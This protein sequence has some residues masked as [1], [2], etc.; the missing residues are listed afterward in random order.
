M[1][2]K[3]PS[4]KDRMIEKLHTG[5]ARFRGGSNEDLT[6][7]A[8][9][10][11]KRSSGT[12]TWYTHPQPE[13]TS[14]EG[15]IEVTEV[16]GAV[17]NGNKPKKVPPEGTVEYKVCGSDTLASIAA[18]FDTTPTELQ[19]LNR[20]STRNVFAGQ[21][22]YV[23]ASL[24]KLKTEESLENS[25]SHVCS[26]M[27]DV[28]R[29][30][31]PLIKMAD[32]PPSRVPGHVERIP[33]PISSPT[34]EKTEFHVPHK[35][36]EEEAR[37][38]DQECYERFIKVHAKHITDGQA[39]LTAN[40]D[41]KKGVVS[42]VLLVTPNAVMFDPNVSD[43]LVLEHGAERYGVIA[44]MDMVVSAAM[45][46]DIAA[47]KVKGQRD[48]SKK[49]EVYHDRSC[50][51]FKSWC[52]GH[53][54]F[55][56]A[57]AASYAG[58]NEAELV[59]TDITCTT[60]VITPSPQSDTA[61]S[62]SCST[63]Q[64][65]VSATNSPV[66]GD[67]G[68]FKVPSIG[69]VTDREQNSHIGELEMTSANEFGEF[70]SSESDLPDFEKVHDSFTANETSTKV[71]SNSYEIPCNS[72]NENDLIALDTEPESRP[73]FF[74]GNE[75]DKIQD[76]SPNLGSSPKEMRIGNIVYLPV[77]E[78]SKGPVSAEDIESAKVVLSKLSVEEFE[79]Q[80]SQSQSTPVDI[81][82]VQQ[83][84]RSESR[85][86]SFG[87][88]NVA[89]HLNA[90]VNYATGLFK[91]G[92][93]I[94][95]VGEVIPDTELCKESKGKT[96][97]LDIKGKS[98]MIKQ[99]LR[100]LGSSPKEKSDPSGVDLEVAVENAV[101]LADKPEL[102]QS[103]DKLIPR[104]AVAAEDPP[105]YLC[106]HLGKPVNKLVS[107]TAPIQAYNK[108]KKKP[109]Y[110]FSIPREKVDQ[111]YAF[112]VQW[113][114]ELYGDEEEI[115]AERRGFV[116]LD[117]EEREDPEEMEVF[118]EYFN[119]GITALQKDWEIISAEEA[120]RR[121]SVEFEETQMLPELHGQST[122][123][124][125]YHLEMLN[126][127]MPPRT[128]GYPWTLVYST[129]QHGFSLKTL[130]RDMHGVDSP[131]MLLVKDTDDFIFGALT[132]CELKPSDHFYGTGESFLFTFYPE[133]KVF[134][135]TGDNNF[136]IKGNQESL[137][138]G[139][140]QGLFGLWFD[141]G[142]YH[143]QTHRCDTYDNDILTSSEDFIVKVLEAWIFTQD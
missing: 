142:L 45:Y 68:Q 37:E 27:K 105:L 103:F 108:K 47:M 20:M 129:E 88:F 76:S 85:S 126:Q 16:S 63:S 58:N 7:G 77:S 43:P 15:Q 132:S 116:V 29:M 39:Y 61:S 17:K 22:L 8:E 23:P 110:W 95:D 4:L 124:Q 42:G 41:D 114:P 31:V 106:L 60:S 122:I 98:D 83:P 131:V 135:W 107:E 81:P 87:S 80:K 133:F 92:S 118:E 130:Y 66:K 96:D 100:S 112:F 127:H 26:P 32:K 138:I 65:G 86:A 123:I 18:H 70:V 9:S 12:T 40:S 54:S 91:S 143:G 28:P 14:G 69:Q 121:K 111:L 99:R 6:T 139:A 33:T 19:K 141:E 51:L 140:G 137:S 90:F 48:G 53:P 93:D 120:C 30:D 119:S 46:H 94:R 38:L 79:Q 2:T 59:P 109:E 75:S 34:E 117:G 78:S 104:P 24:M 128:I 5:T 50:P 134:R 21:T 11:S 74:S 97:I 44:P 56:V 115:S 73:V 55:E 64:G 49:P 25:Q 136:F 52:E 71:S 102:F 84:T 57:R 36:S 113:K 10:E 101:K 82:V 62:C 89:P 125:D 72:K 3:R 67:N 35:L 13:V 1:T